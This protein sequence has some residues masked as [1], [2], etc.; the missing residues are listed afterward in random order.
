MSAAQPAFDRA[1]RIAKALFGVMDASVVLIDG[2]S[3]WRS[4]DRLGLFHPSEDPAGQ[5]IMD[6]GEPLWVEDALADARFKDDAAVVG[7]FR[8]RFYAGAPVQLTDG[9]TLGVLCVI[10]Q[11]PRAFDKSLLNRLRDLAQVVADTC[12]RAKA[13]QAKGG[14]EKELETTRAVLGALISTVPVSIVMTDR[15]M[16]VLYVSPRWQANF[17]LKEADVLGLPLYDIGEGY[18]RPM[19][20][21]Y[22]ACLGGR[23][24]KSPRFRSEHSGRVEWLQSE[25]TPWRDAEGEVGGII[26]AAHYI[27]DLVSAENALIRAKEE[28]DDA[29][30]AK[31]TFL[32]TMSHEIRTPLNGVLGMAQAM[33]ADDLTPVQRERLGVIQGSGE[34]LLAILN[35][36]L[37]LSKIEAGRLVLEE[38]EF[39]LAELARGAHGAF[40]AIAEAKGLSFELTVEACAQGVYRGDPTRVRQILYNLIS[41]ALKFT[42]RGAIRVVA[43]RTGGDLKLVVKDSGIGMDA[44]TMGDIFSKFTQADASTTRKF[45]GTGLGLAI[46]RELAGL[47][48]GDIQAHSRPGKGSTFTVRLKMPWLRAAAAR[49]APVEASGDAPEGAQADLRILVAEDNPTNQLVIRTLLNQAGADPTVVENGAACLAAWETGAWDL[50]LMDVQM[51]VMDGLTATR[52]IRAREAET[53]RARTPIVALTANAMSHQVAEYFAVG[54]D[55]YVSKPIETTKLFHAI[56]AALGWADSEVLQAQSA[57]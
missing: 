28:A 16:R 10:G 45:G 51:P 37:D 49:P 44:A 14:G 23:V 26:I 36:V 35:D 30:S 29:N 34:S 46:S 27:T 38:T 57:A 41:N 24:I 48:G 31:S 15:D 4:R 21:S 42:E 54:M 22:E 12:E 20:A 32:A 50:I 3:V 47:M 8:L 7:G 9:R 18:Y 52:T 5:L 19:Q 13:A 11:E 1:T 43:R 56:E 53:A 55:G 39:D 33:A 25:L 2:D 6:T 17:A 40:T